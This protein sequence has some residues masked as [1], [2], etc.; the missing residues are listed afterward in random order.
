M[1]S[2][3]FLSGPRAILRDLVD[4]RLWP[5]AIVLLVALVAVPV[6]IG[7]SGDGAV[8]APLPAP[9]APAAGGD[10]DTAIAVAAPT[11]L[12][13]SRGGAVRDPFYDPPAPKVAS[14]ATSSSS[15]SSASSAPASAPPENS[16]PGG[17]GTSD[18]AGAQPPAGSP[19]PAVTTATPRTVTVHRARVRWG[20]DDTAAVR[21]LPRLTPLGLASD[22]ALLYLGTNATGTRAA[23]LLGPDATAVGEGTCAEASCRVISLKRGQSVT[24]AVAGQDGAPATSSTLVLDEIAAEHVSARTARDRRARVHADGRNVLRAIIKDQKTA[25]AIGRF[26]YDGALGAVVSITAP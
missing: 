2:E 25:A 24:V 20:Q 26:M 11:V 9:A 23:F 1:M 14:S 21:G 12:G 19:A 18:T 4:K 22:P 10:A 3:R 13:R 5:I 17:D 6:V 7:R 15:S 16:S 8:V